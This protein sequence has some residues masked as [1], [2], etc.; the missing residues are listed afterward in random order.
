MSY[1]TTVVR[2]SPLP[3]DETSQASTSKIMYFRWPL[4][5]LIAYGL[6]KVQATGLPLAAIALITDDLVARQ[7]YSCPTG[8]AYTWC[9]GH[10]GCCSVGQPCVTTTGY[11][12][13]KAPCYGPTC[14][15]GFC[16]DIGF[17][18]PP[19][20]QKACLQ[21][22]FPSFPTD[23]PSLPPPIS[24]YESDQ[25]T[26]TSDSEPP[27]TTSDTETSQS[28]PSP[29]SGPEPSLT[30]TTDVIT[31]STRTTDSSLASSSSDL[32]STNSQSQSQSQNQT[33]SE[34]KS[35][36][37]SGTSTAS[38]VSTGMAISL[39]S[40]FGLWTTWVYTWVLGLTFMM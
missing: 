27:L 3:I 37:S 39:S 36:I 7:E 16:C 31:S 19:P 24:S 6:A 26:Y 29:T 9:P 13:C 30:S 17:Q 10:E 23:P 20:G 25:E 22:N 34:S 38:P 2:H 33:Q 32:A 8:G 21:T 35:P 14:K 5:T 4:V 12:K 15:G 18:C 1:S 28:Y 11:V 40:S